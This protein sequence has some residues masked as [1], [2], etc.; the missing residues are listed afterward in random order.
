MPASK[1]SIEYDNDTGR[2]DDGF[3]EWWSLLR[4]GVVVCRCD[5][6]EEAEA[7]RDTLNAAPELLASLQ[8]MVAEL[9]AH[10]SLGLNEEEVAMLRRAEA[11]IAKAEG[12]K[13]DAAAD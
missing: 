10:A 1:W 2:D 13:K 7:I 9:L 12:S 6:E 5:K 8:E 11:V 4:D 3:W